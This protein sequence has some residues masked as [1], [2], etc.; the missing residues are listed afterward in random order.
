MPDSN[1]STIDIFN[2]LTGDSPLADP[3]NDLF[4]GVPGNGGLLETELPTDSIEAVS[5][6]NSES[7]LI[8]ENLLETPPSNNLSESTNSAETDLL[9]GSEIAGEFDALTGARSANTSTTFSSGVFT[10]GETGEVTID[11]LFDG[12][13]NK[14]ELAIFSL[15]G[16]EAFEPGS[17][18]FIKEAARRALSNSELGYVVI[19]DKLEGAKFDGTL[20]ET[21]D[22]NQGDYL[23]VK[24]LTMTAGD[25]FAI[26][27]VP[28]AGTFQTAFDRPKTGVKAPLFSL[29][30]ADPSDGLNLGQMVDVTG[31]GSIF[32]FDD[33]HLEG[34]A[35]R[36]YNDAIFKI[37]GATGTTAS[38]DE[39]IAPDKDWRNTPKGSQLLDDMTNGA[40]NSFSTG[41]FVVG[42]SGEVTIDFL[43]DGSRDKGEL[44][45]F[46]LSGMETWEPGSKA[47]IKEAARRALS[48][49][50]LGYVVIQDKLEGA[51]FDGT[52]GETT[53]YNQGDYLGVKTL[54]MTAGDS[55]AIALV[56]KAGTFQTAFD[57]PKTGVEAPLFSLA[58]ADPFDG[59]NLGQMADVTGDGR[60]FAFD[61]RHLEGSA[62]RDYNDL[63]FTIRGAAGTAA[64]LDEVINPNREWRNTALGQELLD[65]ASPPEP[66]EYKPDELLVKFRA[67]A[68]ETDIESAAT[69]AGAIDIEPLVSDDPNSNHALEQWHV[70]HFQPNTDLEAAQT[71]FVEDANVETVDFDYLLYPDWV[72]NDP[73]FSLLWHL[74]NTGQ[75][76][77]TPDADIN[78]PEA[79][80]VQRG[81]R[82]VVVAVIDSGIDYNHQ[83]LA[84]NIWTNAG[85]VAGDGID[86]DG[87][88]YADDVYGWDWFYDD[89]DPIDDNGHGTHAAGIIGAVGNNNVGI[90]G[91]SPEVSLMSLKFQGNFSG[92]YMGFASDAAKAI[93]YAVDNGADV[94]NASFGGIN[95]S[96]VMFDAVSRANDAG[97]LFV[98]SAGN[99]SSDND[100]SPRYPT[101]YDIPNVISVAAA[102]NNDRLAEFS[103]Y[104]AT[105]VDLVAPGVEI[106]S[107]VPGNGYEV[108]SGTSTAAPH[109]AGAAALLLAEDSSL[110]VTELKQTLMDTANPIGSLAGMTVSEGRLSLL[111]FFEDDIPEPT[112]IDALPIADNTGE[113]DDIRSAAPAISDNGTV[114]FY[115][116]KGIEGTS[117]S[118]RGVFSGNGETTTPRSTN[119]YDP[120]NGQIF[121]PTIIPGESFDLNNS[122]RIAYN[123]QFIDSDYSSSSGIISPN[124]PPGNFTSAAIYRVRDAVDINNS[125]TVAYRRGFPG[126]VYSYGIWRDEERIAAVQNFPA[127]TFFSSFNSLSDPTI[128]DFGTIAFAASRT[129]PLQVFPGFTYSWPDG[130]DEGIF[131]HNGGGFTAIADNSGVISDFGETGS[132]SGPGGRPDF[133]YPI[134]P[135]INNN[136]TVA[137]F[138]NLDTGEGGIFT[139]NGSS[140]TPIADDSGAFSS[141]NQVAIND[142]NTVAFL[143]NLDAGGRG[144]FTG[145]D[146]VADKAVA[147]GDSLLGSTITSLSFSHKGLNNTDQIAFYATLANG[148]E[149]IFRLDLDLSEDPPP[150]PT[151]PE[152]E[153]IHQLG[154]SGQNVGR[155]ITVDPSDNIYMTA[156]SHGDLGGSNAGQSDVFVAKYDGSGDQLWTQQFGGGAHENSQGTATDS[157]GN[158]YISGFTP[159]ELG[160]IALYFGSDND[161]FV[162]KYDSS[163][164]QIWTQ[165]LASP[166]HDSST[167]LATDSNDNIYIVGYTRGNL[168]SPP[169]GN[170][171]VFVAKYDSDGNLAWTQQLGTSGREYAYGIITDNSSNVYISG[172]TYGALADSNGNIDAFVAK[173]DS[174]GN[175]LWIEQ[176]GTSSRDYSFDIA[177]DSTGNLYITGSTNGSLGGSNAGQGDAFVTKLDSNG[178]LVW[179][180]QLGTSSNDRFSAIELDSSGNLYIVGETYGS[181]DG[182]NAGDRDALVAK[183]DSS[184]NLVWIEQLGTSESDYA[185]DISLDSSGNFYITGTTQGNLVEGAHAGGDDIWIAKF[186][187]ALS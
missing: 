150:P 2:G 97:V 23:G 109:V 44:A 161:A 28:K 12:S 41:T 90:V 92:V 139:S 185:Y 48:N 115:A 16:M 62:D 144:I 134:P 142:N 175:L 22:H 132:A 137:F 163:G 179:T 124:V 15:S 129:E 167:G 30:T 138:A 127:S 140:L 58:T 45:I 143:A 31:D 182:T 67:E 113:F 186:S 117:F 49:S 32:A 10:V 154:N 25:S 104:G 8:Q 98:A 180:Q 125:D 112:V 66:P 118:T 105:T 34:S 51:K 173:Y 14:G 19:K 157:D 111:E 17:E 7:I 33:R 84:A 108:H 79:W 56:P 141:F 88:G 151:D 4:S 38:I 123:A 159:D 35:D 174:S 74:D 37:Q 61:D 172:F 85:E 1:E 93:D 86:N 82:D 46:S 165:F 73:D 81:S 57:R 55:F 76:G 136:N 135:D 177:T 158:V 160:N 166:E 187:Q 42:D 100:V 146:P 50:E 53:D 43:F 130:V 155:T 63:I 183:Y 116:D 131:I 13:K 106:L 80:E 102:D 133:F 122:D 70:A 152:L 95:F 9:V 171:D 114:A 184:G 181:L 103:N 83:D 54:A 169:A 11:F 168:G 64:L 87:N 89:N 65:D 99:E 96:S 60:I 148:T 107:T 147:V 119:T 120:S 69:A 126:S 101:N 27:L 170:D 156:Y 164:N 176:L 40:G 77:G 18:A 6:T 94:I 36:D 145:P 21:K 47:F 91:V 39:A 162:T 29:A 153:W 75:N 149:G 20:G 121:P 59:L 26:A 71:I 72:P 110:T 5:S 68:T 78:A 52:L 24:T 3:Q 178:G 128:N